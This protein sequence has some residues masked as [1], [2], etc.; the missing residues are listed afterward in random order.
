MVIFVFSVYIVSPDDYKKVLVIKYISNSPTLFLMCYQNQSSF[1]RESNDSNSKLKD[2]NYLVK[3]LQI[4]LQIVDICY[5]TIV[6]SP[7]LK[8]NYAG[9][10]EDDYN[11][12]IN[13][14]TTNW[15]K[16]C[17]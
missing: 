14:M 1:D 11:A 6:K 15:S 2:K 7:L 8:G 9:L 5:L 4:R 3:Q 13:Y 16:A 12:L 17:G 10:L